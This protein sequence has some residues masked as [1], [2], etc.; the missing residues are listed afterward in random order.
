MRVSLGINIVTSLIARLRF[1]LSAVEA[2]VPQ[3]YSSFAIVGDSITD[4]RESDTN[5]NDRCVL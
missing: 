3:Q 5:G 1:F 4:G 2:L